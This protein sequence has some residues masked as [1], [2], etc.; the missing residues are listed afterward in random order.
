MRLSINKYHSTKFFASAIFLLCA[1]LAIAQ[2]G[3][4]LTACDL[5]VEIQYDR[6]TRQDRRSHLVELSKSKSFVVK[7]VSD[8]NDSVKVFI[9]NHLEFEDFVITDPVSTQSDKYFAYNYTE[10]KDDNILIQFSSATRGN[11][12]C[13]L[14]NR[15]Y[16]ILYVFLN[17]SGV[18]TVRFS[19]VHY[20][21]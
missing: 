9:N 13:V 2:S 6:I 11:C 3:D 8:F 18:W 1:N 14:Y 21:H 7:F 16:R 4:S 20:L 12:R 5:P 19:N 17:S 10:K 15:K